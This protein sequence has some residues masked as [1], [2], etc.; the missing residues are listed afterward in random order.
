MDHFVGN[1]IGEPK[2]WKKHDLR[3]NAYI[4]KYEITVAKRDA[5]FENKDVLIRE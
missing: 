4:Y 2:H 3:L 1:L 5:G